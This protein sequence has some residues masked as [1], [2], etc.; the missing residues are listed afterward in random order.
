MLELVILFSFAVVSATQTQTSQATIPIPTD[1]LASAHH[2]KFTQA[3]IFILYGTGAWVVLVILGGAILT[4]WCRRS[5]PHSQAV[6]IP[7]DEGSSEASAYEI[8]H[9]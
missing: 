4:L 6:R 3:Q 2:I 1:S 8:D 7:G 9:L 5:N